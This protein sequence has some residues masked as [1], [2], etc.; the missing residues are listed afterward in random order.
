V[1]E[2]RFRQ[3]IP[4]GPVKKLGA[5]RGAGTTVFFRPDATIFPKVEFDAALIRE[6]P[7]V[8]SYLHKGV[9]VVFEDETRRRARSSSTP[10]AS[11]RT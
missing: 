5:A 11:S 9:K 7:R 4:Q 2:Q 3:G 6:A 8:A 10:T 1:W